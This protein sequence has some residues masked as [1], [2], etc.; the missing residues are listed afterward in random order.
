MIHLDG[1]S[2]RQRLEPAALVARIIDVM[3]DGP[4]APLRERLSGGEGRE[5]LVMPAILGDYAG[6]KSLTV[7]PGNRDTP[8]PVIGGIFTLFSLATGEPL[9]TI[10]AAELTAQR[11]SAVSAAAAQLLARADAGSLLVLGSGH[12][13]PYLVAAHS[14]VRPIRKLRMWARD[15]DK[16]RLA[17]RKAEQLVGSGVAVEV[18]DDLEQAVRCSDIVSSATRATTPLIEGAWLRPGTHVDLVGGYRPDMREIDDVGIRRARIFVD[19]REA[20]L[21]EAGDIT[22]P[23]GRGVLTTDAVV[24]D[25]AGICAG[26]MSRSGDDEIT[27]FKSVGTAVADLIAAVAAWEQ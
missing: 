18:A 15:A 12:L 26:R 24:G 14:R 9:A 8:R 27:V 4:T 23:I 13:A 17:A 25:L 21:R 6:I 1:A 16:A 7:V 20:A 11:T 5:F 19:D 3:R 10:D 22:D 2:L